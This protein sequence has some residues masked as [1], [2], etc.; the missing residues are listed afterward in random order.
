MSQGSTGVEAKTCDGCGAGVAPDQRYCLN[1]GIRQ[2]KP[3]VDYATHLAALSAPA[4][5]A[6]AAPAGVTPA[7]S[8]RDLTPL[9][10]LGGLTLLGIMLAIGVLIGKGGNSSPVAASQ[11]SVIRV[12]GGGDTAA[13]TGSNGGGSSVDTA[14]FKSDWPDGKDGYTVELG[15]IPK[16]GSSVSDV[17]SAKSDATSKGAKDVGALDSDQFGS[18]PGGKYVIY[19]GV[20]ASQADASKALKGLRSKFPDAQVIHVSQQSGGGGSGG[21]SSTADNGPVVSSV[22]SGSSSS[23]DT[24][25]ASPQALEQ[26]NSANGQASQDELRHL[27]ENIATPGEAPPT[28]NKPP[29]GGSGSGVTIK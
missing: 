3:K 9:V 6:D 27:P 22:T 29:G 24:V 14:A 19:S 5:P 21:G 25:T 13:T 26:L 4:G 16:Q 23:S 7:G 18:L 17:S 15:T 28:D 1:C 20:Y 10:A 11:P 2:G 8:G 12:A